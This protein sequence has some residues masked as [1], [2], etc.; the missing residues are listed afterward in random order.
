MF[1]AFTHHRAR[2]RHAMLLTGLLLVLVGSVRTIH[3][4]DAGVARV[5]EA[6]RFTAPIWS[7]DLRGDVLSIGNVVTTC[8]SGAGADPH[9][10]NY[11]G[12]CEEV[13]SGAIGGGDS[14]RG[15]LYPANNEFDLV[16]VDVDGDP[17][18]HNSSSA[19]LPVGDDQPIIWAGLH[20]HGLLDS[21]QAGERHP[22]W[23][24]PVDAGARFA[25]VL[26]D[27]HGTKHH[28]LAHDR[29]EEPADG[30]TG[31]GHHSYAG[32]A[33]VTDI[34][35]DG[36]GGLWTGAD[37]Q[38]CT[39]PSLALGCI[40]GWSL[41]VVHA[42]EDA[43]ARNVT[44]W[45]GWDMAAV[46]RGGVLEL[47]ADGIVP[48]PSGGEATLGL[49][50]ADG[51]RGRGPES[52]EYRSTTRSTWTALTA[53][54]RPLHPDDPAEFFNSTIELFG[55]PRADADA[56]P[57]PRANLNLDIAHIPGIP[58]SGDDTGLTF[59]IN[60]TTFRDA[61]YAQVIHASIPLFEPEIE[62]VK[63]ASH[64]VADPGETITWHLAISNVGI[65]PIRDGRVV[66]RLP[67]E[68]ELVPDSIRYADGGP[69][70][71]LGPKSID[72]GD[73]EVDLDPATAE[74]RF[75]IGAGASAATGGT[76]GIAGAADGS[77]HLV[78]TF[79]TIWRGE[80]GAEIVNEATA[81]GHGRE[82]AEDP[83]G[84]IVTEDSDADRVLGRLVPLLGQD[85]T[86]DLETA[87][88]GDELAYRLEVENRGSAPVDH[89]SVV[90][91]RLPAGVS[92]LDASDDGTFDPGTS[93]IT[94]RDLPA[95]EPGDRWTASV[96]VRVDEPAAADPDTPD[97]VVR[98]VNRM[99]V[100]PPGDV[101]VEV[102]HPCEDDAAWSCAETDLPPPPAAPP[103]L[104]EPP[105]PRPE[106]E[107]PVGVPRRPASP[108]PR[109][110][111]P[112]RLPR[113]G[114]DP[115]GPAML[116]S[117]VL[118]A[119]ASLVLFARDRRRDDGAPGAMPG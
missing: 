18:T 85:K 91:D 119:G 10:R 3:R 101:P 2:P 25:M 11:S 116:G 112:A 20:W 68:L 62:I 94:W 38:T 71:L 15:V 39:G 6:H 111:P 48:P 54:G 103:T 7:G 105:A 87:E 106:P 43:P 51:D 76:L 74:L 29:W 32:Y 16:H 110:A 22:R 1:S 79:D 98:L 26:R 104:S 50:A 52:V 60:T 44:V 84:P 90:L 69:A 89:G 92:F 75:N 102:S 107:L 28:V 40:G 93:T 65:E 58:V 9:W 117:G 49:V 66:D 4:A 95:L 14:G 30:A 45:H 21:Q 23:R 86:V 97:G 80:P 81:M 57:N 59:R 88:P 108:S 99:R 114:S 115:S 61:I 41:T 63:T 46:Q 13:L 70:D 53:P 42:D 109:P 19:R 36:G 5:D 96:S 33:D 72:V 78:I 34:V 35:R 8:R 31:N 73:D 64:E 37:I 56:D 55:E 24:P 83:F 27:P 47:T 82:L 118:C 67:P 77:D 17:A 12:T 113:T 100:E